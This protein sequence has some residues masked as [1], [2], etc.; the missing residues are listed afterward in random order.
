[1]KPAEKHQIMEDFRNKSYQVLVSTPV[2]EVGV[3]IPDATIIVIESAERFGLASLHQLRGR[4]GRGSKEGFCFLFMSN[5]SDTSFARLKNLE[6]NDSGI[7][8]AEIDME[9]RGQ[10][11]IFG[12]MQHGFKSFRVADLTDLQMLERA[13]NA[14]KIAYNQIDTYP[15]LQSIIEKQDKKMN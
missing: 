2:I 5:H 15:N 10:G 8:L 12:T 6:N 4:V 7:K 14:A 9:Y 11:D 1:M 3:D 13:R